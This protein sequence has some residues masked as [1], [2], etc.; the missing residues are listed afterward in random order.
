M[1]D[2]LRPL[3]FSMLLGFHNALEQDDI[4]I[5]D[6]V[7]FRIE[8]REPNEGRVAHPE[9]TFIWLESSLLN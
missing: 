1:I 4:G 6:Q 3:L 2:H 5:E 8:H 9:R 7:A